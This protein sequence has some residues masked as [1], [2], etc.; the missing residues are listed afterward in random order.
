MTGLRPQLEANSQDVRSHRAPSWKTTRRTVQCFLSV[1]V[2][3]QYLQCIAS[4]QPRVQLKNP[5]QTLLTHRESHSIFQFTACRN[6]RD[7]SSSSYTRKNKAIVNFCQSTA[8]ECFELFG[9]AFAAQMRCK[10]RCNIAFFLCL[11]WQWIVFSRL[12]VAFLNFFVSA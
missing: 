7:E 9:W 2:S 10:F 12:S 4:L 5:E 11:R 3:V 8:V 1:F 6:Y